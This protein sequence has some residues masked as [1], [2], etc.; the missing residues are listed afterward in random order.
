MLSVIF[1]NK[2]YILAIILI[3]SSTKTNNNK[4]YGLYNILNKMLYK[5]EDNKYE[6]NSNLWSFRFAKSW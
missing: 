6:K 3:I 4:I 2:G 1:Y 5:F